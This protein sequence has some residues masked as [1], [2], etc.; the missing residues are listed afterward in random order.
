[1]GFIDQI[2][3][4]PTPGAG[5][6]LDLS[7][8]DYISVMPINGGAV[9][10]GR[11][12]WGR[13]GA[14]TPSAAIGNNQSQSDTG[15]GGTHGFFAATGTGWNGRGAIQLSPGT[16]FGVNAGVRNSLDAMT[17]FPNFGAA[18][19]NGDASAT[20]D[21]ACWRCFA[22]ISFPATNFFGSD[23]GIEW[24]AANAGNPQL[25]GGGA[26]GFGFQQTAID[27][28][29]FI[30]RPAIAGA[31]TTTAVRV[32]SQADLL[33]WNTYEIRVIGATPNTNAILKVLINGR[34]VLTLDWVTDVLGA[35]LASNGLFGYVT[36]LMAMS[37][38]AG[39]QGLVVNRVRFMAGPTEASLL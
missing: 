34:R 5:R 30:R 29:S 9:G 27:T 8:P 26:C 38:G 24:T 13:Q 2:V 36:G 17:L 20:D 1:M 33:N 28:V 16:T 23:L 12:A 7:W 6:S 3:P 35:P 37:G 4:S 15:V 21:F 11:V 25:V 32:T 19:V 39:A 18:A 22:I 10:T 14:N 31:L